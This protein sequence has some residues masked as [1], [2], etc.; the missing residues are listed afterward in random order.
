MAVLKI[1][2]PELFIVLLP[3]S[4][5]MVFGVYILSKEP[6]NYKKIVIASLLTGVSTYIIRMLPIYP[7][8]NMLFAAIIC[9]CIFAW[10]NK[11][12]IMKA[13]PALLV[14]LAVRLVTELLNVI[15]ITEILH[16][17]LEELA[18]NTAKK[19]LALFPS[20]ILYFLLVLAL[21]FLI[22]KKNKQKTEKN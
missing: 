12:N 16:L 14:L 6:F 15:L 18:S 4:L 22:Y 13:V 9:T 3:E 1:T 8:V 19:T 20:L 7:G 17:D 21:Y 11:L 5:I 2:L 10:Y